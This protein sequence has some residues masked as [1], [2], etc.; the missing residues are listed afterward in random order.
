MVALQRGFDHCGIDF[1]IVGAVARDIWLTQIYDEPDR[2]TTKDL[3]LAV[4]INDTTEY[5]ALQTWLV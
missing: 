5:E 1:Y 4:F 3:D 2:R